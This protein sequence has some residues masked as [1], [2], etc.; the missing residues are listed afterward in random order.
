MA[1]EQSES[2]FEQKLTEIELSTA[3]DAIKDLKERLRGLIQDRG[4]VLGIQRAP[5]TNGYFATVVDEIGIAVFPLESGE[6][7]FVFVKPMSLD[8]SYEDQK[9]F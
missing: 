6:M 8:E 7:Q 3:S 4:E 2:R 9:D 5:E 1:I